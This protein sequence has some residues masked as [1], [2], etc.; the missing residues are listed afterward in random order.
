M[1]KKKLKKAVALTY[2]K[3]KPSA[4]V[5]T[6]IGKGHMAEKII[7]LAKQ[8]KVPLE[9]N[10]FL[11][12]SLSKLNV[13]EEIPPDLYEAVAQLLAFVMHLDDLMGKQE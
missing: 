5:I 4:P 7:E 3:D 2:I 9:K 1:E 6:A 8:H 11:A 10:P 13:G 12:E